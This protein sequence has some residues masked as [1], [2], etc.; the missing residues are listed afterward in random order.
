MNLKLKPFGQNSF[1]VYDWD[2]TAEGARPV[3]I[4]Y[5][6]KSVNFVVHV[7]YGEDGKKGIPTYIG[8]A[9]DVKEGIELVE[10][11]LERRAE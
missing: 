10:F 7:F 3:A 5:S 8:D 4:I 1:Q 9:R 11:W 2:N 6:S